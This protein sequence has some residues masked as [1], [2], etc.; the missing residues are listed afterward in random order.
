MK[1]RK[2]IVVGDPHID[3]EPGEKRGVDSA[4]VLQKLVAHVNAHHADADLCL[5]LGDLTNEGEPA[6]YARFQSIIEPLKLPVKL[7][8]GNHDV[9]TNFQSAFPRES[10]DDNGFVQSIFDFTNEYRLITLDTLNGPPYESLR[11]HV[12]MLTPERLAFLENK[13]DEAKGRPVVIAMHHHPF[14]IGLP[15]MDAIRLM[16]GSEF[17]EIVGRYPNVQM[18][19]FG[20]NH[21]QISGLS[22]CIPFTCFKSLSPQTPLDFQKLDPSGGVAEPSSYGVVLLSD[23]GVLVHQ[24]DFL[25]DAIARS[26][27]Q[28]RLANDPQMAAGYQML[29]Q[30]MLPDWNGKPIN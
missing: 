10:T 18:I 4:D 20:H 6:A 21:R 22:H 16:N 1:F 28:E 2:L 17:L 8:V 12:G 7:M 9:R 30:A 5:F 25:T 13:L 29:A 23:D 19:L 27:F 14:E 24:E 3:P 26:N 11:R 15:G